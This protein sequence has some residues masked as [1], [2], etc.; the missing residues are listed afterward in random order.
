VDFDNLFTT[1]LYIK[2]SKVPPNWAKLVEKSS[3]RVTDK[4]YDLAKMWL[5]PDTDLGNIA[6]QINSRAN[7]APTSGSNN[8]T[9]AL[10]S[11]HLIPQQKK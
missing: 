1:V 5:F 2:K 3:E 4:D 7:A 11:G 6:M 10:P 8:V 9:T